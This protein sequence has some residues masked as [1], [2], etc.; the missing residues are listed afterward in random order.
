MLSFKTLCPYELLK[1]RV[2]SGN[3]M[4]F[5]ESRCQQH[6]LALL[7]HSFNPFKW[8]VSVFKLAEINAVKPVISQPKTMFMA[9]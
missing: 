6:F 7:K 5:L 9:I 3:K 4:Y 1:L 2:T 8:N